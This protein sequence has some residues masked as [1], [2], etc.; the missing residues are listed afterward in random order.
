[1]QRDINASSNSINN[2]LFSKSQPFS[3][4]FLDRLNNFRREDENHMQKKYSVSRNDSN[5]SPKNMNDL[6]GGAI[7]V[8]EI[9]RNDSAHD[10]S[11]VTS[12]SFAQMNHLNLKSSTVDSPKS[13]S[14]GNNKLYS[15]V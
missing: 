9:L 8:N 12:E 5:K 13:K 10:D 15:P 14:N 11:I 4:L 2:R 7:P 3:S 1:M 6:R